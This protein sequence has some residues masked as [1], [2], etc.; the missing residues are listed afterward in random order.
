MP[1]ATCHTEGCGNADR[2]IEVTTTYVDDETGETLTV[3]GVCCGVCG[4]MIS[5]VTD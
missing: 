1:T 3:G 5:D 2:P 4:Q